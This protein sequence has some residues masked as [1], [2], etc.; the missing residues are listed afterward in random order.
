MRGGT[1]TKYPVWKACLNSGTKCIYPHRSSINHSLEDFS[2]MSRTTTIDYFQIGAGSIAIYNG[3]EILI[4]IATTLQYCH[5]LSFWAS[6]GSAFGIILYT[7]GFLD[8]FLRCFPIYISL[9]LS[10][11]SDGMGWWL[12][13][14]WLCIPVYH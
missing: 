12:D 1:S 14:L 9:F 13:F 3:C 2:N 10:W 8:L 6:V 11:Q 5:S 7:I 4:A